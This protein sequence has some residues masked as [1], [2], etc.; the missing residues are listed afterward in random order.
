MG[1]QYQLLAVRSD[2]R[3][4]FTTFSYRLLLLE[5]PQPLQK[6]PEKSESKETRQENDRHV[7]H[8]HDQFLLFIS[9]KQELAVTIHKISAKLKTRFIRL[10]KMKVKFL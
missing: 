8:D 9:P 4:L 7:C 10:H 6:L 3:L 1:V 5:S 2:G